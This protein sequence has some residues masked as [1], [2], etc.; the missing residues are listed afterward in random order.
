MEAG[1]WGPHIVSF[2]NVPAL[3]LALVDNVVVFDLHAY[4]ESDFDRY[5]SLQLRS[6]IATPQKPLPVILI[7]AA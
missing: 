4:L 3:A 7:F 2:G 6:K 1:Y 5:R